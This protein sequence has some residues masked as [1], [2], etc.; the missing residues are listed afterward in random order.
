MRTVVLASLSTFPQAVLVHSIGP[1]QYWV[2]F[3]QDRHG[4]N[5]GI[6]D[7]LAA[8]KIHPLVRYAPVVRW[9]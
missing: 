6:G 4:A 3:Q 9:T 2:G 7:N 8:L 1:L 5:C